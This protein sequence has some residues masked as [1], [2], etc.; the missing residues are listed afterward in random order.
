MLVTIS[1]TPKSD[2]K[3]CLRSDETLLTMATLYTKFSVSATRITSSA[4]PCNTRSSEWL[5]LC[6]YSDPGYSSFQKTNQT[7]CWPLQN[8]IPAADLDEVSNAKINVPHTQEQR[9]YSRT[10][11][12][13]IFPKLTIGLQVVVNVLQVAYQSKHDNCVVSCMSIRTSSSFFLRSSRKQQ[14][15][16]VISSRQADSSHTHPW[17]NNRLAGYQAKDEPKPAAAQQ[18]AESM[19]CFVLLFAVSLSSGSP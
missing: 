6:T 11:S 12:I 14:M 16:S 8:N 4:P 15:S 7:C 5:L 13:V 2:S 1:S 3:S 9:F 17:P 10:S 19:G 18:L